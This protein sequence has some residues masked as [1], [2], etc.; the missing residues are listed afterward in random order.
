[1]KILDRLTL[2]VATSFGLGYAPIASGTFGAV[3]GLMVAYGV[4]VWC[5][6]S[7][8]NIA[9]QVIWQALFAVLLCVLAVPVC[10]VAEQ[11]FQKKDDG[12]IVA[13]EALTF[14]VC[15]IGLPLTLVPWWMLC[16]F[17]VVNR[18]CDI[19]K[20]PPARKIQDLPG[21][22]GIVADDFFA[23]LYALAINW[24]IWLYFMAHGNP[25]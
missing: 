6:Y 16:V 19:I 22:L 18:V 10:D 25:M 1:M 17:F 4:A 23:C 11:Y 20:P 12:R 7:S 24:T 14:P 8:M 9:A 2:L 5:S 15:T 13:D 3:P 21:G